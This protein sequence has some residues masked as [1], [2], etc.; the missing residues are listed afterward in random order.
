MK[1][2]FDG[3]VVIVTGGAGG[4]GRS[5]AAELGRRGARVVVNDLGGSTR[6]G[7]CD[8]TMASAIADEIRSAGGEAV[9]N[10][11][12]IA[13]AD[14][15]RL[16]VEQ[17]LDNW[18]RVDAVVHNA[19]IL[20]DAHFEN[21]T[22][23]DYDD[24]MH[25]NLRGTFRTVQAVYRAMKDRGGGRILTVT[26]ASGLCG[27]FGQSVYAATKM[28]VIGLT[29]S[30]AWEGMRFGIKAN[31]IAPAAFDSRLY[32]E[33]NPDGDA[34]LTGRPP[35][36]AVSLEAA[37]LVGLY[38]ASRVTPLALALLHRSCPVTAEIYSAT[39]GYFTRFTL[40]HSEGTLLGVEPTVDDVVAHFSEIRGEASVTNELD[41]EALV[42]GLRSFAPRLK[43]L[44]ALQNGG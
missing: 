6:G 24:I 39:G 8:P 40:S 33:R 27:A 17:A 42:W 37:E 11:E 7:G 34:V 22:D 4:L 3:D 19:A 13:S 12:D 21:V 2:N 18:G 41:G 16:L 28:G 38:T 32:A 10:T 44:V 26:S 14:G 1:V 23:S 36:L 31:V 25:V 5:E 29:R 35:E 43:P 20:R 9:A 30:I 15:P